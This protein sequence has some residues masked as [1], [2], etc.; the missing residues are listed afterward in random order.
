MIKYKR[1]TIN[2]KADLHDHEFVVY[3][4]VLKLM[5]MLTKIAVKA[6]ADEDKMMEFFTNEKTS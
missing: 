3:E 4:D 1:R 2:Q 5:E 6:G